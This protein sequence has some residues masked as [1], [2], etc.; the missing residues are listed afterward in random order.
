MS[1]IDPY[2]WQGGLDCQNVFDVAEALKKR[3]C[4]FGT[5]NR[6]VTVLSRLSERFYE[7][8]YQRLAPEKTVSGEA[9]RAHVDTTGNTPFAVIDVSDTYGVWGPTSYAHIAFQEQR[10]HMTF[11]N[12]QGHLITWEIVPETTG[13]TY[14]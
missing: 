12:S 13:D 11:Y 7:T 2:H 8:R 3:L 14:A 4:E 6:R 10:V 1:S 5:Y 9:V